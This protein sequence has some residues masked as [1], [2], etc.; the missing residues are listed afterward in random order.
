MS[1]LPPKRRPL[2]SPLRD[3]ADSPLVD[4]LDPA[5][6]YTHEGTISRVIADKGFGFIYCPQTE[7]EYFFHVSE[8]ENCSSIDQVHRGQT[9]RFIAQTGAKGPRATA[10]TVDD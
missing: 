8:L 7:T 4:P 6:A 10:V 1:A 5:A 3:T 9:V 2:I